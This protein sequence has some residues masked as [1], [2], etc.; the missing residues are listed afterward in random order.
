[1][2]RI[3]ELMAE[4]DEAHERIRQL[5]DVLKPPL[6]IPPGLTAM[7]ARLLTTLATHGRCSRETLMASVDD[8][9]DMRD[10]TLNVRMSY[11]RRNLRPYDIE[12]TTI[13]GVGYS[14]EGKSRER[15]R[16][17]LEVG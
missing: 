4:L 11:L 15:A 17:L 6:R 14:I 7:Q 10:N 13:R 5:Q 1:M 3:A 16:A 8:E 2:D 12:I 9:Y